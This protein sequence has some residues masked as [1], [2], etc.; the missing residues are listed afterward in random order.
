[1][2]TITLKDGTKKEFQK[3]ICAI[4][5]AKSISDSMA[6]RVMLASLDGELYDLEKPILK[7]AVLQL[8][9][10]KDKDLLL[11]VARHDLAHILAQAVQQLY[12][13]VKF[14]TGPVLENGFFY[15][16]YRE[17]PFELAE[18]EVIEKKMYEIIDSKIPIIREV[19]KKEDAIKYYRDKGEEFKVDIL[20]GIL[21]DEVAMYRQGDFIDLCRGPHFVNTGFAPKYF[22]LN[23][24]SAVYYK[25][26]KNKTSLQR[27]YGIAFFSKEDFESYQNMIIE[28]EKRDHRKLGKEMDL[29][30]LQE[31][32]VGSV[33]WHEKGYTIYRVLENYIREKLKQNDYVEVKTPILVNKILWEKSGHWDKF[34]DNMFFM[35]NEDETLAV[36]PMNCPCH[37]QIFKQ[38]VKSYRDLPLRMAEFGSCHR[39]ESS[40][41]LHGLMRVRG[42]TQDDA[43]IFC[44][45][46]Q[47]KAET[48][49]F[50]QL[51]Q[52]VYKD[53]FLETKIKVKFS[54]RPEVRAGD[55]SVWDLAEKSL[56]EAAIEAGLEL[57]INKG[58][59]A[60]YGPK[61][62]FV[63]TDSIG[64]DWQLGTFQV[65]FILP[66]RLSASYV[67]RD[68]TKKIPVMLHRAILGSFERFIGILIE[69]YA[70]KFPPFLAPI[71]VDILS[72]AFNDEIINYCKDIHKELKQLGIRVN[73]DVRQEKINLKIRES[74]LNKVPFAFVIGEAEMIEK[75]VTIRYLDNSPQKILDKNLAIDYIKDVC[76]K[77]Y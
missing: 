51:L 54:D 26:D 32:A 39:N 46:D 33:F 58:E 74:V 8:V 49:A 2:I 69:H 5:I 66:E 36:K 62:E 71:Q 3:G 22:K 6:K 34:R 20:N 21:D 38:G 1:M 35:E 50:C 19:W 16:I 23:K 24:V 47:I 43:H 52:E 11:P 48:K 57:V 17:K 45:K 40:G 59:G 37:V 64:R 7:S 15:D 61:L 63:L 72:V 68:G 53:I 18:L 60:F 56:F 31:E 76:I 75:K 73:L 14:A 77:Q 41:S 65:D 4:E 28:A 13:N 9:M 67:G 30:H 12:V 27:I 10:D 42:F 70:G 44:E 55:D 29:F 25:G